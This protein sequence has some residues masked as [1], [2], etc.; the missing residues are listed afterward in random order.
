MS[1][2]LTSGESRYRVQAV[3]RSDAVEVS[4]GSRKFTVKLVRTDDPKEIR[5][6]V[7]GKA[8]EVRL[9]HVGVSRVSLALR[10][11]LMTFERSA[12]ALAEGQRGGSVKLDKDT[13]VSPLPGRVVSVNATEGR[14]VRRGDPLMVIEAMKMESVIRADRDARVKVVRVRE[15]DA[16]KRGQPLL[17]YG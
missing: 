13:V 12:S 7:D 4:V 1:F 17:V 2:E 5:A 9:E 8:R 16:V 14:G 11:D 6:I 10:G 3:L 15:G